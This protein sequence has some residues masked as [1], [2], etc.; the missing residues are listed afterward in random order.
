M[1]SYLDTRLA[2]DRV[3]Q[4]ARAKGRLLDVV[5]FTDA[6][7]I[8]RGRGSSGRLEVVG[9][10]PDGYRIFWTWARAGLGPDP[11]EFGRPIDLTTADDATILHHVF[12]EP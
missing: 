11:A 10:D 9:T 4:L 12:D 2:F 7:R 5:P 6:A 1:A 3:V 8:E